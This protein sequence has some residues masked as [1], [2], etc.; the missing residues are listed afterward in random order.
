MQVGDGGTLEYIRSRAE[1]AFP[2]TDWE[3]SWRL[4]RL[5]GLGSEHISFLFKLLHQIL[6]TNERLNRTRNEASPLCKAPGCTGTAVDDLGHSLVECPANQGV[7]T[8]LMNILRTHH[9]N[10]STEA[11]LRL[12]LIVDEE[13]ELPLVWLTA[14]T[15]LSLWDQKQASSRVQPHLTRSTLEANVNILRETRLVNLTTILH[16][17]IENMFDQ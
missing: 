12:E 7:G 11:A 13:S 16:D 15:L 8:K 4:A 3:N 5:G 2:G 17:L 14:A 9:P 6:P 10:L 1:L